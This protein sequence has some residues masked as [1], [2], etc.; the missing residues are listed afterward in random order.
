MDAIAELNTC[1][2]NSTLGTAF[3]GLPEAD[4]R[5]LVSLFR[6]SEYYGPTVDAGLV[7]L[8]KTK[9]MTLA[10]EVVRNH[11]LSSRHRIILCVKGTKYDNEIETTPSPEEYV[12]IVSANLAPE[13]SEY[14]HSAGSDLLEDMA[15][16][17]GLCQERSRDIDVNADKDDYHLVTWFTTDHSRDDI[18]RVDIRHNDGILVNGNMFE[19]T[20]VQDGSLNARRKITQC[21]DGIR[22]VSEACDFA[23]NYP[24]CNIDCEM[25][26]GY[27][28]N[29]EK[30]EPSRC[31]REVC[32]DGLRTRGERCDD[33]NDSTDDGCD[34]QCRIDSD[35]HKCST[36][37]NATSLCI[38]LSSRQLLPGQ[39][40]PA[41]ARLIS[42]AAGSSGVAS[43]ASSSE[44]VI[45]RTV[46]SSGYR[47]TAILA[48]ILG[49]VGVA[50]LLN[51][52]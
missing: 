51:L 21:G 38:P 32:G 11:A 3:L 52:R 45:E 35:T 12:R 49:M 14:F 15:K 25:R 31:W 29:T 46:F 43:P 28:C 10:S 9:S 48:I 5:K 39:P 50:V 8:I 17:G 19:L 37:Y 18:G 40:Q 44:G 4:I 42:Q 13:E 16:V 24:G 23:G 20:T 47:P 2:T 34:N 41:P 6:V 33:G 1:Y 36:V 26:D 30:L 7:E 27:D 22:Q